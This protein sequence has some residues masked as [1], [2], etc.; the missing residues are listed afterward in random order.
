MVLLDCVQEAIMSQ[1]S[2]TSFFSNGNSSAANRSRTSSSSSTSTS[3]RA[4]SQ[5]PLGAIRNRENLVVSN[6]EIRQLFDTMKDLSNIVKRQS[7]Q[8][9]SMSANLENACKEVNDMK[10][11]MKTVI[12]RQSPAAGKENNHRGPVPK[13]LK[14]CYSLQNTLFS[15]F[16]SCVCRFM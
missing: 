16:L 5:E 2:S 8:L 10:A 14:V 15:S 6:R 12:D 3:S 4:S 11:Q 7:A 1:F 9:E 13:Q